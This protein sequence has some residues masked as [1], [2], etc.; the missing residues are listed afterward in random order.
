MAASVNKLDDKNLSQSFGVS[1]HDW[2]KIERWVD[3][4]SEH[5]QVLLSRPDRRYALFNPEDH[6]D[7]AQGL[8][9]YQ[10][11]KSNCYGYAIQ[12]AGEWLTPG[13]TTLL[14]HRVYSALREDFRKAATKHYNK[15]QNEA[16]FAKTV[17]MGLALDGIE[18]I[19]HPEDA[20][21]PGF[22][23]IALF[24]NKKA[25]GAARLDFHFM[26]LDSNGLWSMACYGRTEVR[27]LDNNYEEIKNPALAKFADCEAL[28]G[29]YHVPKDG[30]SALRKRN[31]IRKRPRGPH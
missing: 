26:R 5:G 14:K 10:H 30:V 2:T 16:G 3:V 20:Y 11:Q 18:K 13:L 15:P 24:F 31:D 6:P 12:A 7:L 9:D 25:R 19:N 4:N 28:D 17:S 22:Y 21:R 23:P 27:A 8:Q 29:F 1:S